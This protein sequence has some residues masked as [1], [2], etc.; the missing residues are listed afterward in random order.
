[1]ITDHET[2]YRLSDNLFREAKGIIDRSEAVEFIEEC[3]RAHCGP[4]GRPGRGID[5]TM[6]AVMVCALTLIMLGRSPTYKAIL[7]TIA[8]LSARQLAEVGMAGQNTARIFG[9]RK[10]QK[11]ERDRFIAWVDRR[12]QP[13]DS[14]PDQPAKRITNA[15]H[16]QIVATR[17][18]A[19]RAEHANAAERLRTAINLLI[20]GSIVDPKPEGAQGDLVADETTIDLAGPSAGLGHK[21]H[22]KRGA[23]YFGNYYFREREKGAL[24]EEDSNAAKQGFGVGITAITRVGT[25]TQLHSVAQVI[26]GLDIGKVTSGSCEAI[27]RCID[28]MQRNDLDTRPADSR[29]WPRFTVDMGYS[30]KTS[31]P[32]LMLDKRYT[33]VN[34]YPINTILTESSGYSTGTNSRPMGPI[35]FAG[36]F[37][38]PAAQQ[39]LEGHG[40]RKTRDLKE[41]KQWADHDAKLRSTLPFLMG[42]NSRPFLGQPRGRP[43]LGA[44]PKLAVKIELVC[45]AVQLRV[46]CPLKPASMEQAPYG[47]P[48]ADP[49]WSADDRVC[50]AQS[51]MTLT[52]TDQ[53]FKK[54]QWGPVPTTWDH[55]LYFEAGRSL[56]ENR[57]S[58]LK[59]PHISDM[60]SMKY[61]PRR[62]PMVKLLLALAFA[63][64]NHQIQKTHNARRVREESIDIRWRKLHERLG[65]EPAR[66]PPRT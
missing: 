36:A 3:H 37:Y 18:P 65:H 21:P 34:T 64:T 19:Q 17:T 14:E 7:N 47:T 12:L 20:K 39:M 59:S 15:E 41:R 31:F 26:V 62:E 30:Y 45:P 63:A 58:L 51:T 11:R 35:Q 29:V 43:R 5:Y 57:F 54:A 66:T 2:Q 32:R 27:E 22:L 1:M 48:L 33:G 38:C 52:M 25:D 24:L 6:S 50:C 9:T 4:G 60:T 46:K 13:L 44:T 23:C 49:T 40:I 55:V 42:T 10:E 56:T 16:R 53:Q 8:D 28:H 61:G